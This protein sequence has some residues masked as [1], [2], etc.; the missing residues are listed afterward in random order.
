[1]TE[2][3][4]SPGGEGEMRRLIIALTTMLCLAALTAGAA[5]PYTHARQDALI[6]KLVR[7]ANCLIKFPVNEFGDYAVYDTSGADPSGFAEDTDGGLS[8][9]S[10]G[11]FLFDNGNAF[12]IDFNFGY[13]FGPDAYL[14]GI[15]N[16]RACRGRFGTGPDPLARVAMRTAADI[17][18]IRAIKL[19]RVQ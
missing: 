13:P 10:Y 5:Q 12:G 4:N 16:T 8:V 11:P 19:A 7:K 9:A 6:T 15:K 3:E 2:G 18:R 1:V 17:E 14:V